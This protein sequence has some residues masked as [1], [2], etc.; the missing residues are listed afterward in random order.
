MRSLASAACAR[1]SMPAKSSTMHARRFRLLR[2]EVTT[3][4][5]RSLEANSPGRRTWMGQIQSPRR[6]KV[7]ILLSSQASLSA[8]W[9]GLVQERCFGRA[10]SLFR[11]DPSCVDESAQRHR[12]RDGPRGGQR[13]RAWNDCSGTAKPLVRQSFQPPRGLR[14]MN[15]RIMSGSVRDNITF[16]HAFEQDFYDAVLN[17]MLLL[18]L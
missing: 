8:S 2:L 18:M 15:L 3:L 13:D 9:V 4:C 11:S 14:L 17:G 10:Y 6:W 7:S 16:S 1:S 12:G 5:S